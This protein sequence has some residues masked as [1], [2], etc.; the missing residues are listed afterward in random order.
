MWIGREV[1]PL[2]FVDIYVPKLSPLHKVDPRVKMISAVLL[3]IVCFFISDPVLLF[4]LLLIL[5]VLV[6]STG[7]NL[8]T[9]GSS[10]WLVVRFIILIFLIWPFFDRSGEPVI[11]DLW[12]YQPTVPAMTRALVVALRIFAIASGWIIIMLT[13]SHSKLVRGFVKLGC[14][15]DFGISLSIALRYIPNFLGTMAQ[16]KEAQASRGLDTSRGNLAGRARNMIPV[17]VPTFAIAFRAIDGLS[18]ALVSRAYGAKEDRTY[19]RDI[20]M[21]YWDFAII[22]AVLTAASV[23]M[24]SELGWLPLA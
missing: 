17:L 14:P 3:T 20:G 18:E 15:Y 10:V 8:K 7:T 23:F 16:I 13:T 22:A 4:A 11:L 5:Q 24:V 2:S 21:R 9:Y 6:I 19:Y 12:I 1:A